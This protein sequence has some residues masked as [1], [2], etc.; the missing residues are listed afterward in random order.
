VW[1]ESEKRFHFHLQEIVDLES[2]KVAAKGLLMKT[3]TNS[4]KSDSATGADPPNA[5]QE[6]HARRAEAWKERL[7]KALRDNFRKSP[8]RL[9]ETRNL[10]G[11]FTCVFAKEELVRDGHIRE[12]FAHTV[13]TGLGGAYGNKGAIVTRFLVDDSSFCF[14]TCHLPA[15]QDKVGKRNVDAVTIIRSPG[16][17]APIG[18]GRACAFIR[19]GDGTQVLDYEN[20]FFFGDLNYRIDLDR[21]TVEDLINNRQWPVLWEADQLIKQR[22]TAASSFSLRSFEEAPLNFAPTYKYDPGTTD[23]DSSEKRRIP[24]WCDRILYRD[25][26]AQ[27]LSA[28]IEPSRRR[29]YRPPPLSPQPDAAEQLIQIGDGD[30]HSAP[31][32]ENNCRIFQRH[33]RRYECLVSDHR[34]ISA[35]FRV[36]CKS[37]KDGLNFADVIRQT[38]DD[39]SERVK[40]ML[41]EDAKIWWILDRSGAAYAGDASATVER[42]RAL[43][44][45]VRQTLRSC[46]GDVDA[47]FQQ[48]SL[49]LQ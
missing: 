40:T 11:L 3:A 49:L 17:T 7:G 41:I 16:M 30:G 28:V 37:L 46:Q 4:K 22:Q 26:Y 20:V 32:S 47:T 27:S 35:E 33:Y 43:V 36:R 21:P 34:P 6:L 15:H 5:A 39:W 48:F 10:V 45:T 18:E 29:P 2:K 44:P 9:L 24:A 14:A 31:V 42:C 23:Y 12:C 1:G 8:Y 13:S 38:G 19:G 25:G